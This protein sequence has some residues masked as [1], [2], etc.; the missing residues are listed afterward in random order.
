M[1]GRYGVIQ[2]S[3]V[4]GYLHHRISNECH[5][6]SRFL[7]EEGKFSKPDYFVPFG[8]GKRM[9]LGE[10]L[11][12]AEL[13]IFFVALVKNFRFSAVEGEIPDPHNYSAGFTKSP[14]D[15]PVFLVRRN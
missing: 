7:D 2:T 8:H 1:G 11:A 5:S 10:P 9:C 4:R 14:R 12:K 15:F 6:L 13:F 3:K